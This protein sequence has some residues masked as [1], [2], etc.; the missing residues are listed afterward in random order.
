M[1]IYIGKIEGSSNWKEN[2]QNHSNG[3]QCELIENEDEKEACDYFLYVMTPATKGV[4]PV[5]NAVNDSNFYSEKTVFCI[6]NEDNGKGF[7]DHQLKSLTATGKMISRNGGKWIEGLDA[8][9]KF[10]FK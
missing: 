3:H 4:S 8:V 9:A 6:I 1:K 10:I 2:F 7:N 5:I